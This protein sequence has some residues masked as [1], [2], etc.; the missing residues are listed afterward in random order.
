M[1]LPGGNY[2]YIVGWALCGL[3]YHGIS[4]FSALFLVKSVTFDKS[5]KAGVGGGGLW[6]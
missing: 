6:D 2:P 5:N 3:R 4:C 1:E